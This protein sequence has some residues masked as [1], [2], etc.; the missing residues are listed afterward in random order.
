MV[1]Y[2]K[3]EPTKPKHSKNNT[4]NKKK[5]LPEVLYHSS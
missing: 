4:I 1:F 5:K 2:D 3:K